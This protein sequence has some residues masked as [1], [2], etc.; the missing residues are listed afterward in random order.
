MIKIDKE[1]LLR[2][3]ISKKWNYCERERMSFAEMTHSQ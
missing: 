3:F 2:T 1:I